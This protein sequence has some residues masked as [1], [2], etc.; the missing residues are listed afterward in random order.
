MSVPTLR[1]SRVLRVMRDG[2]VA[3]CVKLNLADPAVARIAGQAGF[4]CVW[5]DLEHVPNTLRD[6]ERSILAATIE[7]CDAL[8]RVSRG[9]YSEYIRP[10]ELDAAGIMVP[11]VLTAEDAREIV[12]HTRFQPVGHR[13]LDGGNAD[14]GYCAVPVEQ[15]L[16]HANHERFVIV[17]IED[18]EALEQLDDIAGVPGIDMLLF[19]P[20][21]FTHGLGIPGQMDD[22]RVHE[23]RQAVA[24]AA[25]R[26]GKFA[27][28]PCGIGQ[29]EA[30]TEMGYQ[31]LPVGADV[32]AL[33]D[34]FRHIVAA[35]TG[36][37]A[38]T[39]TGVYQAD[40]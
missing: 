1:P 21:D 26:H 20:G 18:A 35:F 38:Q 30:F 10:L 5:L 31:F 19:G 15:Y 29:I 24:D 32:V 16:H 6:I 40:D 34:A 13:P 36:G 4:D 14:G 27:G 23:A 37:P 33:G 22:P 25:R 28:T 8:V 39:A 2:G 9:S 11:H 12:Q 7:D 3:K 17:Q